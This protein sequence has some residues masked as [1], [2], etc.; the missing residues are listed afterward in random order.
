MHGRYIISQHVVAVHGN[1]LIE[2]EM[3]EFVRN[4]HGIESQ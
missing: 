3:S 1:T 4:L 2:L